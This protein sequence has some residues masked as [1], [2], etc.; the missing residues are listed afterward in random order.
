LQRAERAFHRNQDTLRFKI[1]SSEQRIE[2][3]TELVSEI[4][5]AI[6]RRRDTRGDAFTMTL[7]GDTYPK[8]SHARYRLMQFLDREIAMLNRSAHPRADARPGQLGGFAVTVSTQRILGTVQ[9]TLAL[10]GAPESGIRLTA[11]DLAGLDPAGLVIRLENRL[12]GLEALKTKTLSEIER[13][14]AEIARARG[15]GSRVFPRADHLAAARERAREIERQL[16]QAAKPQ[17]QDQ[18]QQAVGNAAVEN[19]GQAPDVVR[20]SRSAFPGCARS[21]DPVAIGVTPN[22]PVAPR[23]HSVRPVR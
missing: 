1:T 23:E 13:M 6:G 7:D 21:P 12:N 22:R 5:T 3:L 10:D 11:K 17:Q 15:D 9:A 18:S 2:R 8:R 19:V 14:R 20:I 4:D 16:E